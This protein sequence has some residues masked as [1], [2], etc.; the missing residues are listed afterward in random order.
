MIKVFTA[1]TPNGIKIPMA[2]E[3]LGI[4]YQL[5]RLDLANREQKSPDFLAINPNGRIPAIIDEDVIDESG[6]PLSVFESGAIL[7]YLA[8]KYQGLIGET[9]EDRIRTLEWLFFQIGGVGP[10][11]GQ[12]SFFKSTESYPSE[13]AV[14]RFQE[15]SRRLVEV[16][17][18]RLQRSPWLAGSHYT[19]ADIANY[20]WLRYAESVGVELE[21]YPSVLR[22]CEAIGLRFAIN[23]AIHRAENPD[24]Q[25][26]NS[27]RDRAA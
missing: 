3:E 9:A 20:G 1:N 12:V 25:F 23:K 7:L 5:V 26:G 27:L 10:M 16:L 17:E 14:A 24:A 19:I 2:L 13:N 8:E 15:E 6:K 21:A 18:S 11:F 22:W 4:P